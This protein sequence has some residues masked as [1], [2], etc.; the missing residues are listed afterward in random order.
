MAHPATSTSSTPA[1]A[2]SSRTLTITRDPVNEE[3]EVQGEVVGTVRIRGQRRNGP[4]VA[5]DESVVDNEGAGKKKS[6]ICCIFH[7]ARNFD[8]S[9][10]ESDSDSDSDSDSCH[11]HNHNHDH[12]DGNGEPS[13]SSHQS[14]PAPFSSRIHEHSDD[15]EPNAYERM[16]GSRKKGKR[17]AGA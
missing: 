13:G 6:K 2:D 9:S 16:P 1:P 3:G 10:S 12:S 11:G 7:K 15:D 17:K 5:W 8:E 4:R 14:R